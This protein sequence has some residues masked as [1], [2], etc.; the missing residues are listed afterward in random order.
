MAVM[1]PFLVIG[2]MGFLDLGRAFFY[3]ISLTN[4]VREGARYASENAYLGLNAACTSPPANPGASC[5][6]PTDST[7]CA[8]VQQ[9]LGSEGFSVACSQVAVTPT[10]DQRVNCWTG[11]DVSG[12]QS[13]NEYPVTVTANYQF[14]FITPLIGSMFGGHLTLVSSATFRTDY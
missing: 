1:V 8:Y 5:P 7:V 12:C 10:Q 11:I 6:V 4:A 14:Q 2:M 9:E 3:Q 13:P